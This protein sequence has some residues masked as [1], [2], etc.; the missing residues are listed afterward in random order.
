MTEVSRKFQTCAST[1]DLERKSVAFSG[2]IEVAEVETE[3]PS[4]CFR[5][6]EV[7]AQRDPSD[8][9]GFQ[10]FSFERGFQEKEAK[11][12]EA[13]EEGQ[14]GQTPFCLGDEIDNEDNEEEEEEKEE[15]EEMTRQLRYNTYLNAGG[16]PIGVG[17]VD[18]VQEGLG[19]GSSSS[20]LLVPEGASGGG[21]FERRE[22]VPEAKFLEP[23][24]TQSVGSRQSRDGSDVSTAPN[25][26]EFGE[27]SSGIVKLTDTDM[28]TLLSGAQIEQSNGSLP[29]TSPPS[30][31]EN[32]TASSNYSAALATRSRESDGGSRRSSLTTPSESRLSKAAIESPRV[33]AK[34]PPPIPLIGLRRA[35]M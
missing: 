8:P 3:Y 5:S 27:Q 29:A 26:G 19:D 32:S 7:E 33:S 28:A 14:Q 13:G 15:D 4:S 20:P 17:G 24:E 16:D 10:S 22:S 12:G 35:G 2:S 31:R 30:A 21:G 18:Q 6:K 23:P 25:S 11:E 9:F 34:K 1:G